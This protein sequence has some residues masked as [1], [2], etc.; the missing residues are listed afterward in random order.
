VL[1]LVFVLVCGV[2]VAGIHHDADAHGLGLV[3][4]LAGLLLVAALGLAIIKLARSS[5]LPSSAPSAQ[6][7][8]L[9][10]ATVHAP[11]S[12]MVVPLRC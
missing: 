11:R 10:V 5:P 2:H 4:Q 7:Q 12:R 9:A 3:D 6:H 8:I 1:L